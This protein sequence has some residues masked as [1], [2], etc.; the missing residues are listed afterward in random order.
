MACDLRQLRQR[1]RRWP[2]PRQ[3]R[4]SPPDAHC[5][6]DAVLDKCRT[7]RNKGTRRKPGLDARIDEDWTDREYKELEFPVLDLPAGAAGE[8]HERR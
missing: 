3:S 5:N 2:Y 6:F 1:P 8:R 4:H 7:R